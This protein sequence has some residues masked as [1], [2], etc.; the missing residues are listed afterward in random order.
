MQVAR[1]RTPNS[2]VR[3]QQA[4]GK[5][6]VHCSR[7][8]DWVRAKMLSGPGA[9]RLRGAGTSPA[10]S[11]I[12]RPARPVPCS[13]AQINAGYWRTTRRPTLASSPT[14]QRHTLLR[15]RSWPLRGRTR[16]W[17]HG[18][19]CCPIVAGKQHM[20]GCLVVSRRVC[21][22]TRSCRVRPGQGQARAPRKGLLAR[23]CMSIC[24]HP[25]DR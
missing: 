16:P 23:R 6:G 17:C 1:S 25:S 2:R 12:A 7:N 19:P 22:S 9:S 18:L 10:T 13:V 24:C 14:A 15:R 21:L 20:R 3:Y 11:S 8:A 5:P 4:H